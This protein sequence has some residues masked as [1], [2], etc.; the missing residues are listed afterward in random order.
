MKNAEVEWVGAQCLIVRA[1]AGVCH[2]L[3]EIGWSAVCLL[4]EARWR[5]DSSVSLLYPCMERTEGTMGS[6]R[7]SAERRVDREMQCAVSCLQDH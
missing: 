7:R 1:G 3:H 4:L 5:R 2:D 6:M